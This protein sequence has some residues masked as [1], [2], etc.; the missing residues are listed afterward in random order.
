MNIGPVS[1]LLLY[2]VCD[3]DTSQLPS[4]ENL[5]LVS[6]IKTFIILR[7]TILVLNLA[8]GLFLSLDGMLFWHLHGLI[9]GWLVQVLWVFGFCHLDVKTLL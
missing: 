1:S 6:I 8:K 4:H 3:S 9:F 2:G 5:F 7:F